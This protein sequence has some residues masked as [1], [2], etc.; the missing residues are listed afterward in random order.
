MDPLRDEA[1]IYESVLREDND[2][3]THVHVFPGL[4]HG[5]WTWFPKAQFSQDFQEKSKEG[6]KWLLSQSS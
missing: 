5:F 4:P 2:I 1:F 3:H 6:L